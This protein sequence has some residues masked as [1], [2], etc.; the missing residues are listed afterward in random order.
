MPRSPLSCYYIEPPSES[1]G[2]MLEDKMN[3]ISPFIFF[4][5]DIVKCFNY[6]I[7]VIHNTDIEMSNYVGSTISKDIERPVS[8][9]ITANNIVLANEIYKNQC[10]IGMIIDLD[11]YHKEICNGDLDQLKI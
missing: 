9:I 11:Y 5:N 1:K 8:P 10:I 3:D 2:M 6:E 4:A 7:E